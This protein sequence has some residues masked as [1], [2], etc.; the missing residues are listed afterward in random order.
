MSYVS[1]T[2]ASGYYPHVVTQGKAL[3]EVE[4]VQHETW[5][6]VRALGDIP[7]EFGLNARHK[8]QPLDDGAKEIIEKAVTG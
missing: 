8:A 7:F 1:W 2:M 5:V 3:I 4:L 6:G